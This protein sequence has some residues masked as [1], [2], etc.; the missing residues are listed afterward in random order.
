MSYLLLAEDA[1]AYYASSKGFIKAVDGVT[2]HINYGDILGVAGESGC[3]KSTLSNVLM[4][5]VRPPLKFIGG[6]IV[7]EGMYD[8]TI[9]RQNELK[10]HVW[11]RMVAL[12]PQNALNALVPTRKVQDFIADVLKVKRGLSKKEA[13]M[14]ARQ[15]FQ[16]VSL[17]MEA[18]V[19]YPH[20]LSG[21]MRQRVV[22]A[23]ATLLQPKLLIAD[24]P[25]SALDVSTQKQVL[26]MLMR[27]YVRNIVS[28]IILITHDIAIL[29]Q[30]ATKIG[31][32]Y[33]G[34][35][36]EIAPAESLLQSPLHPYTQGLVRCVVTPEPEVKKRGLSYISGEP[37]DLIQPPSG[38]RFHPRCPKA[39][40]VCER[41]E[42]PL[43]SVNKTHVV[44][45]HFA[46]R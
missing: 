28:S 41:E 14:L 36:V 25:T 35:I 3:G 38:C 20:Q 39:E 33:A 18:L 8:L 11:G 19:K 5:N 16:E 1:R 44:A 13:M 15:R 7:L 37:P 22:I 43:T 4:M 45:C 23:V 32:M 30:I 6:K 27:L 9:M 17:P 26:A 40:D 10:A 46:K 29:R 24:E 12:I 31:I 34:K 21:G 42:P 2:I